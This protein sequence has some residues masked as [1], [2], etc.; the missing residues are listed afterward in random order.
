MRRRKFGGNAK[1]PLL[2]K[3]VESRDWKE[4]NTLPL[5][6]PTKRKVNS[7]STLIKYEQ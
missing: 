7:A 5:Q 1:A 3:V 4:A 2:V 6:R